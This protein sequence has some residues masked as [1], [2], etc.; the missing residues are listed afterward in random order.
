[1]QVPLDL[2]VIAN[3]ATATLSIV[4][5]IY[6]FSLWYKQE[7]HL[8]TDLPLMFSI[9][10]ISHGVH[11]V[12]RILAE[13]GIYET[14]LEFFRIR[15]LIILGTTLPVLG[16][17]LHIWLP[18]F[19]RYHMRTLKFFTFYWCIVALL[20]PSEQIIMLL[21]IPFVIVFLTGMLVTFF[22]TW[23]TKRLKEVRSD[24]MVVSSL[25]GIV[26]QIVASIAVLSNIVAAVAT[27]IATFALANP[28]Y[29]KDQ[30]A[31]SDSTQMAY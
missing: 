17:I 4:L 13:V 3:L 9:T 16:L 14:T 30:L 22:I 10:F 5:S 15:S 6:L 24:L 20:G 26:G 1:M 19:R 28:W 21:H 11:N 29:R 8:Y 12:I 27:L 18:R 2:P 25:V 23:K 31:L 7:N